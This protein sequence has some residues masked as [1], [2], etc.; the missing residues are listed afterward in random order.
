MT[1]ALR[2][3]WRAAVED[4]VLTVLGGC[5]TAG[6]EQLPT[7]SIVARV[8]PTPQVSHTRAKARK[9]RLVRMGK[10]HPVRITKRTT[11]R[12]AARSAKQLIPSKPS[13]SEISNRAAYGLT[14][15]SD[16]QRL[17]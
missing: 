14:L 13:E 6:F 5:V 12:Q 11:G 1:G 8:R 7:T 4:F 15:L 3:N 17:A 2:M 9:H 10:H 16:A